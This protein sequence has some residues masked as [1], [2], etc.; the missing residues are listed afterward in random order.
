MQKYVIETEEVKV[1][2]NEGISFA[3]KTKVDVKDEEMALNKASKVVVDFL[4]KE[5]N[6]IYFKVP[7]T[8]DTDLSDWLST[9][10][11]DRIRITDV[12]L[13]NQLIWGT[14]CPYAIDIDSIVIV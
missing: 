1:I 10:N 2:I 7:Y 3:F 14:D 4:K 6:D 9:R 12:D 5:K 13:S 11:S 8:D